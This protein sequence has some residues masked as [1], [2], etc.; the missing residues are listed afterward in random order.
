MRWQG[1]L[2]AA[3][4]V[5]ACAGGRRIRRAVRGYGDRVTWHREPTSGER[6]HDVADDKHAVEP[7]AHV[8]SCG[9][10]RHQPSF[11]RI[12]HDHS[13]HGQRLPIR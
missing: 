6:P 10:D 9:A 5:E 11:L 8:H 7:G 2:V 4:G 12:G 13:R 1:A 3:T